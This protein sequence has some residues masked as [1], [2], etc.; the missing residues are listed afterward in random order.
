MKNILLLFLLM[1]SIASQSDVLAEWTAAGNAS[2]YLQYADIHSIDVKNEKAKLWYLRDF[3]STEVIGSYSGLSTMSYVEFNCNNNT[4]QNLSLSIYSGNMGHGNIVFSH[5][6]RDDEPTRPVYPNS[7]DEILFNLACVKNSVNTT[8]PIPLS[9][10]W[11]NFN[12]TS[13]YASYIDYQ[14]IQREKD[15]LKV[16]M[17]I[18]YKAPQYEGS[19]KFYSMKMHFQ[20]DC[21]VEKIKIL[22]ISAHSGNAG[23]GNVISNKNDI[24]E[25]FD[26]LS[27]DS[28]GKKII[29][30]FCG[31]NAVNNHT[32]NP[33]ISSDKWVFVQDDG[34]IASYINFDTIKKNGSKVKVWHLLDFSTPRLPVAGLKVSS[35]KR[36]EEFD[37]KNEMQTILFATFHPEKQG[38]GGVL[39]TV[40]KPVSSPVPPD[41]F[42]RTLFEFL[43][44]KK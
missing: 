19:S 43:C 14:S 2:N 34:Q 41:T 15:G 37:C 4:I 24:N 40:R 23:N 5:D 35:I 26:S 20:I 27:P 10:E 8:T 33:S 28:P 21:A 9:P 38:H 29:D 32:D 11:T 3:K 17:M 22:D 36:Q 42:A 18:D 31:K 16:W 13:V 7:M 39:E 25:E 12:D 30:N 1:V 6:S 44:K